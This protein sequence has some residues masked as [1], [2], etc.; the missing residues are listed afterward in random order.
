MNHARIYPTWDEIDKTPNPLT[1]GER[2][3]LRF[4]D[5]NLPAEWMIFVQPYLNGTRPDVIVFNPKV[6]ITIYEVKDWR[7][8]AY[9]WTDP[10]TQKELNVSDSR[11][12]YPVKNPVYQVNHYRE[13]IIGQ[14]VP[15]I[16]ET[17]D[18]EPRKF[19]LIKTA[20]YFHKETT[21]TVKRFFSEHDIPALPILGHDALT[22]Q[23]LALVV[24]DVN[25]KS[26]YWPETWNA[27][28]L[29]W[30]RPPFHSLEQTV[31]LKLSPKQRDHAEPLRGH[32]RLRGV[33]GSGKTQVLAYRAAKLASLGKRV[34]I[35]TFNMTLWHYIRDMM[36]RAPFEFEWKAIT[37]NH[38]HGFC[39]D[40]LNHQGFKWPEGEGEDL[41]RSVIVEAVRKALN[42]QNHE[43][44]DAVMIDEGQDYYWEW[45]DLLRDFMTDHNELLL[46]CDKRQNIYNRE[47]SWIDGQMKNVL[48]R[49]QWRELKTVFRLPKIVATQVNEFSR[50]FG[51]SQEVQMDGVIENA[52]ADF[53]H[54]RFDP[55][56]VWIEIA[57]NQ[58]L[59]IAWKAFEHL[60]AKLFSASDIVILLPNHG[61]G[62]KCVEFFRDKKV[63]VNHVF[64]VQ[65]HDSNK[66][67]KKAFWNGD[68]R[69]KM[70]TIH[71]FKGWECLNV[72]LF[73]PQGNNSGVEQ[74]DRVV[75]TAMTRTRENLI[76]LNSHPRYKEFG[77]SLPHKW[78]N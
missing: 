63:G 60:K 8:S 16:G 26:S 34:L 51:L 71:S 61:I 33:A 48:F 72:I 69:L 31:Q 25:R 66:A 20:V 7:L 59:S 57:E 43:K 65:D 64:E 73:I 17:I 50:T 4:L 40:T 70:C 49:G 35:L 38:F 62:M 77:G 29:F 10:K 15:M 54:H 5:Q 74:L 58:L 52:Q 39:N 23:N 37:F 24:P 75:Y 1:E 36:Q 18:H 12:T 6:G 22:C 67:H 27:E 45:Y 13:K 32:F 9:S 55:H 41:F 56:T 44:W 42:G 76:V 28:I 46:V 19:G 53:F 78:N 47:M 11:G 30:L 3:L 21:A 14:L 68:G 2:V